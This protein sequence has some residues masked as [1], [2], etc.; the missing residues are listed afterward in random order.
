MI[1]AIFLGVGAQLGRQTLRTARAHQRR[2]VVYT[3]PRY[4]LFVIAGE[5]VLARRQVASLRQDARVVSA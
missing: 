1:Q 3:T 4:I 2:C 5:I